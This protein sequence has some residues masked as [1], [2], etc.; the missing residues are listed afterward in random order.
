M[1]VKNAWYP[2]QM[3]TKIVVELPDGSCYSADLTPFRKIRQEELQ[4]L[5]IFAPVMGDEIPE[6]TLR[7]YGLAKATDPKFK[8]MRVSA[9]FSQQALAAAAGLN[10]RQVQKIEA[11]E[12]KLENLTLGNAVKLAS[13]L[14]VRPE[15][16]LKDPTTES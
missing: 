11:G 5:A 14:G 8:Q 12:I 2:K 7:F 3:P 10:I 4:K 15:D 9:G 13:A 6:H 1:I 16:L